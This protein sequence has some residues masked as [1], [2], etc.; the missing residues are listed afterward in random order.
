MLQCV[1]NFKMDRLPNYNEVKIAA[2]HLNTGQAAGSDGIPVELFMAGNK[3][4][5]HTILHLPECCDG[6]HIPQNWINGILVNLFKG[7]VVVGDKGIVIT[8]AKSFCS[9]LWAKFFL[10]YC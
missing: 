2:N 9:N 7:K 8:T 5:T 6:A 3:N 10:D 4:I 1:V